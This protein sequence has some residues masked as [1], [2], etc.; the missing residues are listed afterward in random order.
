MHCVSFRIPV[1]ALFHLGSKHLRVAAIVLALLLL[2]G[3]LHAAA[4]A[5]IEVQPRCAMTGQAITPGVVV[6]AL[7]D[8]QH[9]QAY[10][11]TV[12]ASRASGT[13]TLSGTLTVSAVGGIASFANL[14]I[15]GSGTHVIRFTLSNGATVDSV[16]FAIRETPYTTRGAILAEH[17]ITDSVHSVTTR[18]K[19]FVPSSAVVGSTPNAQNPIP[20]IIYGHGAGQWDDPTKM[21]SSPFA[22]RVTESLSSY[23]FFALFPAIS[24]SELGKPGWTEA[25][26]ELVARLQADGYFIDTN[27]I[28]YFGYSTGAIMML[29][30][31]AKKPSFFAAMIGDDGSMTSSNLTGDGTGVPTAALHGS[32]FDPTFADVAA[33]KEISR[34]AALSGVAMS[35]HKGND[36]RNVNPVGRDYADLTPFLDEVD[37]LNA[38]SFV[39]STTTTLTFPQTTAPRVYC[40]YTTMNHGAMAGLPSAANWPHI[41]AWYLAQKRTPAAPVII[42][43]P[44]NQLVLSG[45]AAFFRVTASGTP[46]PNYQWRKSTDG[47][48]SWTNITGATQYMYSVP[49]TALTDHGTKLK[50]DVINPHGSV[51]SGE[52]TLSITATP[53]P[54]VFTMQPS[55]FTLVVNEGTFLCS[56]A[57]G[58]P[59]PTYQWQKSTDGGVTWVDLAGST[60]PVD[61]MTP[62][63]LTVNGSLFRCVASNAAGQ[64][65]SNAATLTL[66][67]SGVKPAITTQPENR[68]ATAGQTVSFSIITAGTPPPTYQWQ[69][70][71][72]GGA[73]WT[74][75]SHA[76]Y[77]TYTIPATL[78]SQHGTRFRCQV[79]NSAGQVISSPAT[80]S[81]SA[82]SSAPSFTTQPENKSVTVGQA[83]T[84]LTTAIG[85]PAPTYKWQK[86]TD[87]GA[88]WNVIAGAISASYTTPAT[89]IGENGSKFR[90]VATNSAA[91]VISNV[92]TL[93]VVA[94][95]NAPTIE[96]AAWATSN[97]VTLPAETVVNVIASDMDGDALTY[98]WTQATGSGVATFAT[99]GGSSS[100]VSFNSPGNYDLQVKISDSKGAFATSSLS[101][102]VLAPANTAPIAKNQNVT[103]TINAP[104][105]ITLIATDVD[106]DALSYSIRTF[107][108]H[109]TLS[110]TPPHLTYTPSIGYI[111]QD[112][113]SF[114][115]NDG[116]SES[117]V[118]VVSIA[119]ESST[120]T[121]VNFGSSP[122]NNV[123]GI[124]GWTTALKDIY[125]NYANIGPAG[126][127]LSVN[128]SYSYEGVSGSVPYTF[129]AGNK[130]RVTYY[131]NMATA[132]SFTPYLSFD[133]PN[134]RPASFAPVGA[135]HP[136]SSVTVPANGSGY[137]E[138]VVT[139]ATAG[140]RTLLNT[141][142]NCNLT[143]AVINNNKIIV[144]KIELI[145]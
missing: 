140:T 66:V 108:S 25:L 104:K 86:S 62:A 73:T 124:A 94:A 109:G 67:S 121:I 48:A 110:G 117:N 103:T 112:S 21:I 57:S 4:S 61:W 137:A 113:F 81:V 75:I 82:A 98:A 45:Q 95:N 24:S 69:K 59:A 10:S 34:M 145:K 1:V 52:A 72:D 27:R 118:G 14:R 135:W 77:A 132:A 8:G 111:G 102:T 64:V 33:I 5:T 92:V 11:G 53:I 31:I 133:D 101:I 56:Y 28:Y 83:A 35:I 38:P 88:T 44:S 141:N 13:G 143:G 37:A 97:P 49:V 46:A 20:L 100:S 91:S 63:V 119:V 51:T 74:N 17:Q 122:A 99:P 7:A 96:S 68:S 30:L 136:M 138:Y 131:N 32:F 42:G 60:D 129:S 78:L 3:R 41:K 47:G 12:T 144:D 120:I 18:Y 85:N 39:R 142:S 9:N 84:F 87:G 26:P 125:E 70:S 114:K 128:G 40:K 29:D 16:P 107:P 134:R 43:Q 22:Q 130:I 89:V 71:I 58:T 106:E 65:A 19:L 55:N 80:L 6:K 93:Q 50:C 2:P 36:L 127:A 54:P 90:C 115:A 105:S 116:K 126:I 23:P 123:Y 79:K 15:T 76:L 139:S